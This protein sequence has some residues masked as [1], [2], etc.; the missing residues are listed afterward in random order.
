MGDNAKTYLGGLRDG[1]STL[2][3]FWLASVARHDALL[4]G[5][6]AGTTT[7]LYLYPHG[8][9]SGMIDYTGDVELTQWAWRKPK[10]IW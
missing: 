9:S 7:E 8:D 3:C 4:A 2:D 1:S 10:M 6:A 5:F